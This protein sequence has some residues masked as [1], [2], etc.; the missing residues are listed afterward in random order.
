MSAKRTFVKIVTIESVGGSERFD[1][2]YDSPLLLG[3]TLE[4]RDGGWRGAPDSY[5]TSRPT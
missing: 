4:L 1:L 5:M 3:K 2:R